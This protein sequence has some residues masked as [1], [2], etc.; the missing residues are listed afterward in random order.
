MTYRSRDPSYY[1]EQFAPL[2]EAIALG[3][4][5]SVSLTC[6]PKQAEK[7]RGLYYAWV[8]VLRRLPKPT[9]A[10]ADL[11]ALTPRVMTRIEP[12]PDGQAR[13]TWCNRRDSWQE[14]L[15]R[16]GLPAHLTPS[17]A[18][19]GAA[20]PELLF[21]AP[22]LANPRESSVDSTP[23]GIPPALIPQEPPQ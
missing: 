20:L 18:F 5:A 3:R 13:I 8:G 14:M 4:T 2:T 19:L 22:E 1:P 6:S 17:E 16:E 23:A 7:L 12:L 11:A 10:Q 9:S 15:L 21:G